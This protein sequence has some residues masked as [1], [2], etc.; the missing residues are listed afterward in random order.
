MLGTESQGPPPLPSLAG[1]ADIL[2]RTQPWTRLMGIMGFIMVGFMMVVGIIGGLAGIA[3]GDPTALVLLFI[4]PVL[5]L[6]YIF[7]ALYLVRYSGR[8]REFVSSGQGQQLEAA[9]DA[10][11]AF[12]KFVGILSLVSI[13]FGALA[14][15]IALVAGFAI[16]TGSAGF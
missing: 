12:W 5:A 11:R 4:Y 14:F 6:L 16:A 10:Q 7:P 15:L 9:L 1:V 13:V 3:T 8:I 2:R